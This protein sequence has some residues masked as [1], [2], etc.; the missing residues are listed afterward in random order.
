MKKGFTKT[1]RRAAGV[2][3]AALMLLSA[4]AGLADGYEVSGYP[5]YASYQP[6]SVSATSYI[7][8]KD[9]QAYA[10]SK[11]IDGKEETAWQFSTSKSKL[12]STYVY[13]TFSS[14]VT[15]DQLW[16]KN[17]FWKITNGYDQYTRNSRVKRMGVAYQYAGKKNYTDEQNYS[18]PDDTSRKD[19]QR[20]PLSPNG[21]VQGLRIRIR[22]IY[23]GSKYKTD[24]CISELLFVNSQGNGTTKKTT[25]TVSYGGELYALAIDRLATREGPG[26]EYK[27]LGTYRV[28]GQMIHILAKSYD[29]NGVCW[30][31]CEIPYGGK[32]VIAWT[33][34]KRFDQTTLDIDQVPLW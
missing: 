15:L 14:A 30:V 9:P 12:G 3:L 25:G 18:L 24:V 13:V 31:Q 6:L 7:K 2:V 11:L 23:A 1:V 34:W 10:P 26:T 20:L 17:G 32:T 19:W 4:A 22:E 8:G 21:K 33:G 27:D 28:K 5:G 29:I 16:I